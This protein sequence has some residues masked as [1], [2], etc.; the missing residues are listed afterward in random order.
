M[1]IAIAGLGTV[2]VGLIKLLSE[3]SAEISA[4]LGLTPEIIAVS[5]R[6]KNK[7]RGVDLSKYD[8]KENPVDLAQTDADVIIELIGGTDG[9]ALALT[10]AA[11]GNKKHVITANKAMLDRKSV[12]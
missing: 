12:V 8:W 9:D 10:K 6:S 2:G 11:L 4:R 7:D 1:K 3:N 5:A